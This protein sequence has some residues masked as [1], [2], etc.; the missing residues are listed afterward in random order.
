MLPGLALPHVVDYPQ[1]FAAPHTLG[2]RVAIIG[3]GG[4]AVDLAHLL[5]ADP[6]AKTTPEEFL[7]ARTDG[8]APR[9][10][11]G[12]EPTNTATHEVTLLRRG[13]RIGSGIGASTRWVALGELRARGVRFLTGVQY[14]EITRDGILM[15][16]TDGRQTFVPADSVVLVTGQESELDVAT[17]LQ[18]AGIPFVAAGGAAGTSRLNA[19]RAT[20]EGLRAA[21]SIAAALR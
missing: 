18:D 5:T 15:R 8:S 12:A 16:D 6:E 11:G 13:A 1:A 10:T 14:E 21:H 19:V 9:T 4:I 7:S 2:R 3:G 20:A 17:M